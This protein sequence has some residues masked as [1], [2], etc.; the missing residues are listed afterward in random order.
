MK[1]GWSFHGI[2]MEVNKNLC[3]LATFSY[4]WLQNVPNTWHILIRYFT[5]HTSLIDCKVVYHRLPILRS[6]KCNSDGVVKGI[7][8]PNVK[9]FVLELRKEV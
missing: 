1:E 2:V 9:P 7:N 4:P 3:H 8:I 5:E 6:Y